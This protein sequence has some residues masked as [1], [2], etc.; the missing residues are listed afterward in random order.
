MTWIKDNSKSETVLHATKIEFL[1]QRKYSL[2]LNMLDLGAWQSLETAVNELRYDLS[3]SDRVQ[4]TS[5][6]SQDLKRTELN[7]WNSLDN[8]HILSK[9]Q[10][11]LYSNY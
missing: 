1:L 8:N 4:K 5:D 11:S 6:I 10:K 3:L 7:R 9:L 2:D